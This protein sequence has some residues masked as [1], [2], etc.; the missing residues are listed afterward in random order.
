MEPKKFVDDALAWPSRETGAWAAMLYAVAKRHPERMPAITALSRQLEALEAYTVAPIVWL[1]AA[2]FHHETGAFRRLEENLNYSA[3]ALLGLWPHRFT[4][5]EARRYGR[6]DTGPVLSQHPADPIGIANIAY[7]DRMGNG[8][9]E[10]G[11]G[12]RY[13]GR[14]FIQLTGKNNYRE[15]KLEGNPDAM[16]T[17]FDVAARVSVQWFNDKVVPDLYRAMSDFRRLGALN[18]AGLRS[19][20]LLDLMKLTTKLVRGSDESW[21]LRY[22]AAADDT[23]DGVEVLRYLSLPR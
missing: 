2:T 6:V 4:P 1:A 12:W 13:R 23:E 7:A 14:G 19:P 10:S 20:A 18:Q 5:E 8:S 17:N 16:S 11:D 22:H 3:Q 15:F 9:V 21:S